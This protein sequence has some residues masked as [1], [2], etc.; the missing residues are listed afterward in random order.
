MPLTLQIEIVERDNEETRFCVA[1]MQVMAA[2]PQTELWVSCVLL[3]HWPEIRGRLEMSRA[4]WVL[5]PIRLDMPRCF[6]SVNHR[7][8]GHENSVTPV[9]GDDVYIPSAELWAEF[10][11]KKLAELTATGRLAREHVRMSED[12]DLA[13]RQQILRG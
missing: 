4:S 3:E 6:S 10:C 12:I 11:E 13:V 8:Y 5:I 2:L 1:L 7:F 9:Y